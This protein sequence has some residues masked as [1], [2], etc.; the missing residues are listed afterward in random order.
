VRGVSGP[1]S[2]NPPVRGVSGPVSGN[3]PVRGVSGPV[4]GICC[5]LMAFLV[6]TEIV[7]C[8][9]DDMS[10]LPLSTDVLPLQ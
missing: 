9:Y 4:S 10:M 1:V 6:V 3:P 2:G 7:V 8:S 5:L